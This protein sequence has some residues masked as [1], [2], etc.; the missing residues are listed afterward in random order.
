MC[1][2]DQG[3]ARLEPDHQ[4]LDLRCRDRVER[5][6]RLVHQQ[7]LRLRGERPGNDKALLLATGQRCA[8]GLLQN[9]FDLVEQTHGPQSTFY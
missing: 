7:N 9:V 4:F 3:V 2:D 8:R 6:C 1:D 5:R